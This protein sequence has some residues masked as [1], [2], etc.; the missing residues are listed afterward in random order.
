MPGKMTKSILRPP[1]RP[2]RYRQP[3]AARVYL[4]GRSEKRK[5][6]TSAPESSG[7]SRLKAI[8]ASPAPRRVAFQRGGRREKP[9][10]LT[11]YPR[12]IGRVSIR[13][14]H[15]LTQACECEF[16]RRHGLREQ[17]AL[18]HIKVTETSVAGE[19]KFAGTTRRR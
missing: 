11:A 5:I 3:S 9:R 2:P 14:C 12:L 13:N 16:L 1:F 7:E 6:F 10:N 4:A 19:P 17:K 15:R 8:V 18:D